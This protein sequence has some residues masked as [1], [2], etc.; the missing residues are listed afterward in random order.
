[1]IYHITNAAAWEEAE[2]CGIYRSDS[3]ETQGFIHCS[4]ADQV[5]RVANALFNGEKDLILLHIDPDKLTSEII[6]EN[7]EGGLEPFPHVYG[8]IDVAAVETVSAFEPGPDG[9]FDHHHVRLALSEF[10]PIETNRLLLHPFRLSDAPT[11]QKLAGARDVAKTVISIPHPYEDGV[12]EQFVEFTHEAL[13]R[14]RGLHLA[15]TLKDA[16]SNADGPVAED[17]GVLLGAI[18]LEVNQLS[19]WAE[20]GY[21]IGVPYWNNGYTTEA[22]TA[23]IAYGF[24]T[25]G[26][27][28]IQARHML[29]NPASGRVMQKIGMTYEGT[30]RQAALRFGSFEDLAVYAILRSEYEETASKSS[31]G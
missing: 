18:G 23:L 19:R 24:G 26:L 14:G 11:I 20:L 15:I 25:L 2:Q 29:N 5:A 13:N 31:P 12:A 3:L 16:S 30:H 27:N 22:A 10:E 1:M 7:V 21:W 9:D 17:R 8:P 4:D 28:R 6:Y